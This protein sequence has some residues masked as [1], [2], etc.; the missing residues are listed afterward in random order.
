MFRGRYEHNVDE[1][2]R[3]SFPARFREELGAEAEDGLVITNQIGDTCLIAYPFAAWAA[4]ERK[5]DAQPQFDESMTLLRR[6]FIGAAEECPIDKQGRVLLPAGLR[7]DAGISGDVVWI[8]QGS[9]IEIWA[10]QT[11][12]EQRNAAKTAEQIKALRQKLGSMGL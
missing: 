9:T 8:G 6:H 5:V 4:F 12:T 1:K 2:G 11:W 7:K 3:T 10:S